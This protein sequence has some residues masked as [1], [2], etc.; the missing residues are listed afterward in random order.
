LSTKT[1][2]ALLKA[3]YGGKKWAA[4]VDEMSDAQVIAVIRRLQQQGKIK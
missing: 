4:R 2:R 3:A 1:E